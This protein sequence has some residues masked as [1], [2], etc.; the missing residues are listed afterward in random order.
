LRDCPLYLI[1]MCDIVLLYKWQI[2]ESQAV[3]ERTLDK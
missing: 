3:T 2:N 1:F